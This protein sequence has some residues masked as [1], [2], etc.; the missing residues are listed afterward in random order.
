MTNQ[1]YTNIYLDGCSHFCT[2]SIAG[3][4][5]LLATDEA[6]QLVVRVW[7]RCR[8]R[9]G[10]KILGY[11][12][13]PEHIHILL[14]GSANAVRKFMQYSLADISL[15]LRR[16]L[17]LGAS[18]GDRMA[19]NHLAFILAGTNGDSTAK[20][21][22]ERFRAVALDRE[23]AIIVKLEYMHNNPVKRELVD[24]PEL[25]EWSSF[26][27]YACGLGPLVVDVE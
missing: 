16:Q 23:D 14:S 1:R 6:R 3:F 17:E 12:I 5:P 7:N 18:S 21:W 22:K 10:V 8:I 9:Y 4:R 26:G 15:G 20:V 11:V 24:D 27:Y 19:A 25:W 13:M 2:A